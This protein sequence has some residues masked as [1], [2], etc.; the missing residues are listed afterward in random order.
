VLWSITVEFLIYLWFPLL[1]LLWQKIGPT[2]S[3]VIYVGIGYLLWGILLKTSLQPMTMQYLGA[4]AIGAL[5]ASVT[6]SPTKTWCSLKERVPWTMASIGLVILTLGII[7]IIGR[8]KAESWIPLFDLPIALAA[9]AIIIRASEQVPT[10]TRRVLAQAPLVWVGSFSFSLY[11][12]HFPLVDLFCFYLLRSLDGHQYMYF[13]ALI[14][15]I[16]P[17]VIGFSY[18]FH[19]LFERPFHKLARKVVS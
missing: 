11:M 2:K 3:T 12:I 8:E 10:R 15:V 16:I 18:L 6:Y 14:L 13:S 5:A 17:L 7:G 9:A 4:F 19:L 1:V